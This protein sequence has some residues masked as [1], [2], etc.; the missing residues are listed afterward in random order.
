MAVSL[1]GQP[2]VEDTAKVA[3][4]CVQLTEMFETEGWTSIQVLGVI[5]GLTADLVEDGLKPLSQTDRLAAAAW[6]KNVLIGAV[7]SGQAH[8]VSAI[9]VADAK[10]DKLEH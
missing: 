6:F 10:A 8:A 5:C 3:K 7:A 2:T 9:L 1:L 4:L